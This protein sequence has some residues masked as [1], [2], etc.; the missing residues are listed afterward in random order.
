MASLG[1]VAGT[2]PW[3]LYLWTL[4]QWILFCTYDQSISG[5]PTKSIQ[6]TPI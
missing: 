2:I 3:D 4:G 5:L 6:Y 1:H